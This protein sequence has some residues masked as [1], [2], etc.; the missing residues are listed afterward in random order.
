MKVFKFG[1]ASIKSPESIRNMASII[2]Q[3]TGEQLVVVVSAMGKTTNHL[4]SLFALVKNKKE[5][6]EKFREIASYHL[7]ISGQLIREKEN[8]DEVNSILGQ[9]ENSF[10]KADPNENPDKMYDQIISYGELISS[11]IIGCYLS[12]TGMAV[13]WADARKFIRTDPAY[14]EAKINWPVTCKLIQDQLG[15]EISSRLVLTQGFIGST[16]NENTTTLGREGS[17]FTAAIIANC[18]NAESV[19]IWK[20]VPGILNADPKRFPDPKLYDHL[21]FQ[22]AAEMT[23]YGASV[24]HPKTIKP[25]ANKNIPLFV[26]SF[27]RP[28]L[29][30][31]RIDQGGPH[32]VYPTFVVKDSQC[33]VS[34]LAKD[35]AFINENSLSIIFHV[36]D[37]LNI[38]INMMQNSAVSLTICVDNNSRKVIKMIDALK[39]DFSIRFN[40]DLRLITV[41]NYSPASIIQVMKDKKILVEQRTRNTFQIV[42]D[43]G[44]GKPS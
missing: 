6:Q 11:T 31:T 42:F 26:K 21:S 39:N 27:E 17:D 1:G 24:I 18:L 13:R 44:S 14:R 41:K 28:D 37:M 35:L 25:L 30:G 3:Y 15:P 33:L 19:T 10:Q 38:K 32:P 9:L 5:G 34:F 20:D 22:E 2:R 7:E 8:R 43:P 4:E 40:E 29:P 23:Y 16:E 36:L 12:E